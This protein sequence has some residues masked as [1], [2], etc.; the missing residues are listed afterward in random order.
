[1]STNVEKEAGPPADN[2]PQANSNGVPEEKRKREYKDFGHEEEAPTRKSRAL[3]A[4]VAQEN[5]IRVLI[6]SL[7]RCQ[8][9]HG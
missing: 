9:R 8:S 2:A 6:H 3:R 1:M 4:P 7:Y 5:V